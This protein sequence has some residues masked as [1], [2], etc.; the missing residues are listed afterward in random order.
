MPIDEIISV[1]VTRALFL[2]P[3]FSMEVPLI[4]H[5]PSLFVREYE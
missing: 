3:W 4:P 5:G 2:A 1:P